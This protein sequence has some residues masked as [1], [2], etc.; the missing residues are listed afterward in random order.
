MIKMEK[1][2]G[3]NIGQIV[4]IM[5]GRDQQKYAVIIEILDERFVLIADGD[6]RK[7]DSP[8]RKNIL[9][10]KLYDEI[11][12]EVADSIRE[13]GRVTNG[14]IRYALSKFVEK[15]QATAQLKGD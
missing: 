3:Y 6:K 8:K 1:P 11:S 4:E 14:K 7:F 2:S 5:R 9:H 15:Q 12:R 13:S 10:L